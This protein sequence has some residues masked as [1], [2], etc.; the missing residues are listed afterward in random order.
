MARVLGLRV[1][2][3]PI[4]T[5]YAGE[6][7]HLKPIQYGLRVLRIVGNYLLGKYGSLARCLD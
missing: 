2:E 6:V 1:A 4:P 3:I 7:S 5:V